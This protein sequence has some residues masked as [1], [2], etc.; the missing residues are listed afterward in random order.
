MAAD[1]GV[2]AGG[3]AVEHGAGGRVE[4]GELLLG[5]VAEAEDAH[6]AVDTE[7]RGAGQLGEAAGGD[8]A[9]EVHLSHAVAG[10][11]VAEGGGGVVRGGGL[12]AGDAVG[13][14]GD[15]NGGGEAG[16]GGG[17][18]GG[19]EGLPEEGGDDG[20]EG[21]EEGREGEEDTA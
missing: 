7:G 9:H 5:A 17:V 14:E 19:G 10:M 12:D 8:A 11:H 3:V 13:I 18:G 16:D 21:R 6:G 20:G 15:V 2:Y 4:A 1:P